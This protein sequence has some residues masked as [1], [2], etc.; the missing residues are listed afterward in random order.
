MPQGDAY[1]VRK[2]IELNH[3]AKNQTQ[4]HYNASMLIKAKRQALQVWIAILAILLSALAPTVSHAL[5]NAEG[6]VV[7]MEICTAN[8][9]Q[10]V[11]VS[12]SGNDKAPTS[13]K[14]GM[15]H[16]A[17]CTTGGSSPAIMGS[18]PAVLAVVAGRDV[19]PPLFYAAPHALHVWSS[20]SPRA[21]PFLA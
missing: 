18:S 9:Y 3:Q 17:Y 2:I 14:H 19:Y 6:S 7:T 5:A 10:V 21:P 8:G 12:A 11:K 16:C 15:E 20:A 1:S 13:S 4:L